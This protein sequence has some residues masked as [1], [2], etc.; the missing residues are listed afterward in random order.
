MIDKSGE[1]VKSYFYK[2]RHQKPEVY[3]EKIITRMDSLGIDTSKFYTEED[4]ETIDFSDVQYIF[5]T[6]NMP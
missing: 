6:W 5:S 3:S 4:V 1:I 2:R